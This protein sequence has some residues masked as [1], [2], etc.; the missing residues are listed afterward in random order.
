[1]MRRDRLLARAAS[2]DKEW[3]QHELSVLGSVSAVGW[4]IRLT[5]DELFISGNAT[6]TCKPTQMDHVNRT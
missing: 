3:T 1:V 6:L 2:L 4:S 5:P